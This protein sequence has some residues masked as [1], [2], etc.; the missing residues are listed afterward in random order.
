MH[1]EVDGSERHPIIVTAAFSRGPGVPAGADA[2]GL[3]GG[4]V[5][6]VVHLARWPARSL[7]WSG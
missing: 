5:R 4:A 7:A 3:T 6:A 2:P 1:V